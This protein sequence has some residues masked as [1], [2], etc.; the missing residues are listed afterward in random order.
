MLDKR[1]QGLPWV[2]TLGASSK[3]VDSPP[4]LRLSTFLSVLVY[5]DD[6]S[7]RASLR[8]IRN[9]I[10]NIT[11]DDPHRSSQPSCREFPEARRLV[12]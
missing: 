3:P 7:P 11:S 5:F 12:D 8:S 4:F 2:V 10:I 9:I 6:Y 1:I